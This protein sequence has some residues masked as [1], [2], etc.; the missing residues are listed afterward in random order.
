MCILRAE[1]R[2]DFALSLFPLKKKK[3]KVGFGPTAPPQPPTCQE[4][5]CDKRRTRKSR[6]YFIY[7]VDL[8]LCVAGGGVTAVALIFLFRRVEQFISAGRPPPFRRAD[9]TFLPFVIRA[10][11]IFISCVMAV[12]RGC[13]GALELLHWAGRGRADKCVGRS[14]LGGRSRSSGACNR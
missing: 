11:H 5:R 8:F 14:R 6:R 9:K 12:A 7:F 10:S 3:R 4:C 1:P 2:D 13:T